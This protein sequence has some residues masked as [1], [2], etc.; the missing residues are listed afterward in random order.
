MEATYK[1]LTSIKQYEECFKFIIEHIVDSEIHLEISDR[2]QWIIRA[3][4][5][6]EMIPELKRNKDKT[7]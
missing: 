3:E 2:I 4:G 1:H 5:C 7:L 6:F